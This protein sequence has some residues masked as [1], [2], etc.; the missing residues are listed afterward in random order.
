MRLGWEHIKEGLVQFLSQG[1]FDCD[2]GLDEAFRQVYDDVGE[3]KA[4]LG[5][6]EGEDKPET[7]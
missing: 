1:H 6:E 2:F 4:D 3:R 5:G 7:D